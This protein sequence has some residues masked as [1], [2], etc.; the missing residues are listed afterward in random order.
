M[1]SCSNARENINAYIDD[2]LNID[3]RHSFEEHIKKCREC[4]VELDEMIKIAEL[5]RDLPQL[6]LPA[7]F[8]EELH[9]KLLAVAVKQDGNIRS[10]KKTKSFF[11]TKTFASIAA[12][13]LLIF[14]AGSFYRFGLISPMRTGNTAENSALAAEQPAA[15]A[16]KDT[17]DMSDASGQAQKAA[18][19]ENSLKSFSSVMAADSG[20]LDV[21]RS[22]T[23]QERFAGAMMIEGAETASNKVSTITITSDDTKALAEKLK[24]LVLE[25]SG[26][27]KE[28]SNGRDGSAALY[29][30]AAPP[31]NKITAESGSTAYTLSQDRLSFTIPETQYDHF[32]S[33]LNSTF[34]EAN[35]QVGAFVTEDMTEVLNNDI[36][37]A[38]EIDNQ[39]QTLKEK[40]SEKN[41]EELKNL[42][43]E[44]A[45]IESQVEEI[46]LG[47]DFVNVNIYINKE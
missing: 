24:T 41:A 5:C 13:M 36:T 17:M 28:D 4:K 6:E 18:G 44:K 34:G 38:N 3:E 29:A 1:T 35:V 8:K 25:N 2:E 26:D 40:E 10:I 45:V 31:E 9:E 16:A 43:D 15:R 20:S 37:R 14:L 32:V 27:I 22:A 11:L 39:I 46:R 42:N 33:D 23:E 7:D 47:S 21:N 19:S 30:G 12:G